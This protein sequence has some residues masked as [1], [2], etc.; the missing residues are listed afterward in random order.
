M[1]SVGCTVMATYKNQVL[2]HGLNAQKQKP[3]QNKG[4]SA[5]AKSCS[6]KQNMLKEQNIT[7]NNNIMVQS[8]QQAQKKKENI[9]VYM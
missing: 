8:H 3:A 5:R 7:Y 1:E 6:K 2:S 4:K 9:Y